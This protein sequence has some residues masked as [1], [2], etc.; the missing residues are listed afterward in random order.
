MQKHSKLYV[1]F[2]T[3]GIMFADMWTEDV[4]STDPN[5]VKWPENAYAFRMYS[6]ESIE[7]GGEVFM[8]HPKQIGKTYYH[9]DSKVRT[10][11]EVQMMDK[12]GEH[13][14]LISNM[15]G[16]KWDAVVFTRWGNFPQPYDKED[17]EVLGGTM[18]LKEVSRRTLRQVADR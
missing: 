8:A 7:E 1:E 12:D 11:R 16:N 14:I 10:L 3:P 5:D 13:K 15:K 9:P 4:S 6:R 17:S 18:N 2:Q